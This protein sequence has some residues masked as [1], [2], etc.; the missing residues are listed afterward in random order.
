MLELEVLA[1][2]IEVR[3]GGGGGGE[4]GHTVLDLQFSS[5]NCSPPSP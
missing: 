3:S 1:M 4:G 2:L 5:F